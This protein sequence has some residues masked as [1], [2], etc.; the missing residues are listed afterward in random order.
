M[1]PL[2]GL[3]VLDLTAALSGPF[4]TMILAD[5]G[6]EV[7][8][9]EPPEGEMGRGMTPI[10]TKSGES[11]FFCNV[12][13]NK[14]GVTLNLKE[15]KARELFYDLVKDADIVVEN[16]KGGVTKRLKIDYETL[17][18]INPRIIYASGS[19]FGQTGPIT[20][21]PCFDI[22]AQA[23]GGMLNLTGYPD[24]DPVKVGPSVADHVSGI[25]IATGILLAL[26]H[27]ERTGEGQ[28]VDV[29]MVDT[30][31]SLLEN[32]IPTYTMTGE[33]P[34]RNGNMDMTIQPFDVYSC[35][36]GFVAMGVGSNR[37]YANLCNTI[38]HPELI[39]DPRYTTNNL[40][41]KNYQPHLKAV[42]TA[43]CE[44]HTKKE[45]EDIMDHAGIPC[46]PVLTVK[47]AIE[48]PHIRQRE[49][50]IEHVHPTAGAMKLQGCVMKLSATPGG[51]SQP[52][53]LLGQHNCE[54]FGLSEEE[55]RR[56][57]DEGV[58]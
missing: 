5:Y 55:V 57:K 23:M 19:G 54:V 37:M 26:Y 25:Y 39:D 14:K 31:F 38:G 27:R 28:Q 49:M 10:D 45:I 51:V 42:I 35:K 20:H 41:V 18:A 30:I 12:N 40:R 3:R 1:R 22:V 8:K 24:Q 6:A 36:D 53:P 33:I 43:W 7:I 58:M 2:E 9:I 32:A 44:E 21:R 13:R 56:L 52:S 11:G 15:E 4:C 17:R 50:I 16:Y 48:H 29:S 47:E 34:K 46:G